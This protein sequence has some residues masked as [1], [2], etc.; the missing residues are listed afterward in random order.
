MCE[1]GILK[2]AKLHT[3]PKETEGVSS[4]SCVNLHKSRVIAFKV[5][6]QGNNNEKRSVRTPDDHAMVKDGTSSG[7]KGKKQHS[8]TEK[9]CYGDGPA[10][11]IQRKPVFVLQL[12]LSKDNNRR[13]K[14][15]AMKQLKKPRRA[16]KSKPEP[17]IGRPAADI[18]KKEPEN[19]SN[20]GG[21][22]S[23]ATKADKLGSCGPRSRRT[24]T[25]PKE[26]HFHEI[27][28]PKSCTRK[29]NFD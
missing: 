11:K 10:P 17:T 27:H 18:G 21:C 4:N 3:A 6:A 20:E 23:S 12:H 28:V 9:P 14:S 29:V 26:P 22:A 25:I 5:F 24:P 2:E 7:I 15:V 16:F 1:R 19:S 13:N 8:K